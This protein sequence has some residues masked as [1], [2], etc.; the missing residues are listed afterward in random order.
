M[1]IGNSVSKIGYQTFCKCTG[2]TN[3]IIPDSVANIECRAF[4]DCSCL[5]SIEIPDSV[6]EIG[7]GAFWGCS[8]LESITIPD[9]VLNIGPGT[10]VGCNN[11]PVENHIRYADTFI[12]EVTDKSQSAYQ[13]K[14]G[15]RFI[16][17]NAFENCIKLTTFKI[18]S[19]W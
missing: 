6:I 17:D 14:E 1:K 12:V 9:S 4:S 10:F 11:L 16:G 5:K 3:V 15:T 18:P 13:I 7:N 2:L 8:N 19:V